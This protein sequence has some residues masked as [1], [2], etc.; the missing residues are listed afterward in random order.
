MSDAYQEIIAN[1][2]SF[3]S[4][5][6]S[7]AADAGIVTIDVP[8][9]TSGFWQDFA[10]ITSATSAIES[11][12]Y[13]GGGLGGGG[14]GS[15]PVGVL[16]SQKVTFSGSSVTFL[17]APSSGYFLFGLVVVVSSFPVNSFFTLQASG[18]PAIFDAEKIPEQ[19]AFILP[20][21]TGFSAG[22]NLI[23]SGS[24]GGS[25]Q[26]IGVYAFG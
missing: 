12:I 11:A 1:M 7:Q 22:Q 13:A 8:Q 19:S 20:Q 3:A 23:L 21:N 14:G 4:A 9:K 17:A 15:I 25:F 5:R 6:K 2:I 18:Q 26:L 16:R 10:A 24:S